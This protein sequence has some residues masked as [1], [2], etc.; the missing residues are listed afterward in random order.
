MKRPTIESDV[1]VSSRPAV[2]TD[3]KGVVVKSQEAEGRA[4]G[5][6]AKKTPPTFVEGGNRA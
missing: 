4:V 2:E 3:V 6:D 1:E 5:K